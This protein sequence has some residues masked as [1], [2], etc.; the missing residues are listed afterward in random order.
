MRVPADV[1][2]GPPDA[3][4][5]RVRHRH[6]PAQPAS[7]RASGSGR[8]WSARDGR[9]VRFADGSTLDVDV[10]VWATGYR[11][12]TPGSTSP[13]CC[14]DGRSSTGAASPTSPACTSSAC[15]GSTPAARPC[16]ASSRR[17]GTRGR[18]RPPARR[19]GRGYLTRRLSSLA[20]TGSVRQRR[21]SVRTALRQGW[22]APCSSHT[23]RASQ[24]GHL[25]H[26]V[27]RR[28]EKT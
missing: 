27:P 2:A 7:G 17:R 19:D 24:A 26:G 23:R 20:V 14:S 8:G 1:A 13:A 28:G 22:T 25:P 18:C 11:P 21:L 3:G 6:Q 15:P 16:S 4:P 5:R 9:T 12:T 10:V